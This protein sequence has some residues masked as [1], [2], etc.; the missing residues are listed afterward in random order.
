[1]FFPLVQ[2]FLDNKTKV[3]MTNRD[4]VLNLTTATVEAL[5]EDLRVQ[6]ANLTRQFNDIRPPRVETYEPVILN[7]TG[8]SS[9]DLI[10][11]LPEFQ[12]QMSSYP[13]WRDAAQFAMNYY[14]EGSENFYIATGILRNKVT[15]VANAKL[16]SFNTVLNFKAIIAR[17][18]QCFGD[19]RSLQVLENELSILRQGKLTINDFYDAVDQQLTLI[20]NKN[21]MSYQN[22]DG[23]ANALNE[24]ARDNA[25]RVF[26]SGLRKPLSD[27]LFS[28]RPAD[29]PTALATAQELEADQRRQQFARIFA[30]GSMTQVNR[31]NQKP[32]DNYPVLH[33]SQK[34]IIRG[35]N[36]NGNRQRQPEPVPMDV[37]PGSSMFR[38]RTEF[39]SNQQ[40][41][42]QNGKTAQNPPV[43]RELQHGSGRSAPMKKIQR[44]NH[45]STEDPEDEDIEEDSASLYNQPQFDEDEEEEEGCYVTEELNFLE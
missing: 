12:G 42:P 2:F 9:L 28:A 44:V 15:G 7:T 33:P 23:I 8:G 17:L 21:K 16:S 36:G 41:Q 26:I 31:A 11:S 14:R 35:G 29:L 20:V 24:R 30:E 13:A 3:K 6:I 4:E 25:L 27:I 39:N 38:R 5:T 19:K 45:M 40:Q 32:T 37:D 34:Q 18:D 43:K 1:M 10:K 22:N